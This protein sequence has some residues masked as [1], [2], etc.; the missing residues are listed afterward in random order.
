[1]H[2]RLFSRIVPLVLLFSIFAETLPAYEHEIAILKFQ[3]RRDY[4]E[5][6][7]GF[8]N[9]IRQMGYT[10]GENMRI[11]YFD[12]NRDKEK[13]IQYVKE[14]QDIPASV[15]V[16][17]GGHAAMLAKKH[18][19]P[20]IPIVFVVLLHPERI[21]AEDRQNVTGVDMEIPVAEKLQD[22]KRV[23]PSVQNVGVVYSERNIPLI[24]NAK[25]IATDLGITLVAKQ[26]RDEAEVPQAFRDL[27]GNVDAIWVIPDLNVANRTKPVGKESWK[28]IMKFSLQNQIPLFGYADFQV[29]EG[30]FAALTVDHK[31]M[32]KQAAELVDQ[33]LKG[34]PPAEIPY[35]SARGFRHINENT[36]KY[37]NIELPPTI[38]TNSEI[39]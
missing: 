10:D 3:S 17:I 39:H 27:E 20:E 18:L 22:I 31:D 28:F 2:N 11:S 1:M 37:L 32:G 6:E 23:L 16:A 34:T 5:T 14:I 19:P 29:K 15:V 26:I 24:E 13:G 8:V 7:R 33:V 25:T 4:D 12:M 35:V 36:A 9:A 30:A 38:Q 21:F